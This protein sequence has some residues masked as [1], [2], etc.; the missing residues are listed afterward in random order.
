MSSPKQR[1]D[2]A[3]ARLYSIP[4]AASVCGSI[5]GGSSICRRCMR[6]LT[7]ETV[8]ELE[9]LGLL[10][11]PTAVG[12]ATDGTMEPVYVMTELGHAL[13]DAGRYEEYIEANR[14]RH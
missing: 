13:S 2:E 8:H 1:P 14:K 7:Q 5:V 6:R 4:E 9:R 10:R 3:F 11:K 12:K